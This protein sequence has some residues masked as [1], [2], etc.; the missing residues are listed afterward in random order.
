MKWNISI[1]IRGM[2]SNT[3]GN[4]RQSEHGNAYFG[5]TKD[6]KFLSPSYNS[7]RRNADGWGSATQAGSLRFGLQMISPE[8]LFSI[9]FRPQCFP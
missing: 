2:D 5:F 3:V 9:K 4:W 8:I 1:W 7:T 6:K